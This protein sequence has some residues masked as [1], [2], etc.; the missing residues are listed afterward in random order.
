MNIEI[1]DGSFKGDEV[2]FMTVFG[3]N[4]QKRTAKYMGKVEGDSIKGKI[5]R[6]RDG[7]TRS[8]DW[9]AKREK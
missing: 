3:C 6:E 9:E 2:R 5:E 7:E 1:K 4:G 8:T